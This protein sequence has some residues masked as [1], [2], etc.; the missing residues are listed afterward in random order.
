M[1]GYLMKKKYLN[2]GYKT[3]MLDIEESS[4]PEEAKTFLHHSIP[5]LL[6]ITPLERE[7]AGRRSCLCTGSQIQL[8]KL[9]N[10]I[11]KPNWEMGW[12]STYKESTHTNI[13]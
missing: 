3:S 8:H 10:T 4:I 13:F 11:F 5:S 1:V 9:W 2:K 12:V 7:W 6:L